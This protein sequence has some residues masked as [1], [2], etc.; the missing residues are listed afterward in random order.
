MPNFAIDS[1]P[2]RSLLRIVAVVLVAAVIAVVAWVLLRDDDD[3][4]ES[5]GQ[6]A[7][8]SI[9]DLQEEAA[10]SD[11][12]IFWAGERAGFSYELTE[13]PQGK[14]VRY[15]PQG[16]DAGDPRPNFLTVAT[17]DLPNG[18]ARV[19]A[20]SRRPG[21]RRRRIAGGG[22]VLVNSRRPSSV[23]VAY[24]RGRYQIEVYDPTPGRALALAASGEI[25]QVR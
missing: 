22:L 9:S 20:A 15:L 14:F 2:S 4:G 3:S 10:A 5:A 24:P 23:Y 11:Q 8:A 25:Q 18:Y 6:P 1:P 7:S 21:A 16:V 19:Q 13:T 17:Y 12:P